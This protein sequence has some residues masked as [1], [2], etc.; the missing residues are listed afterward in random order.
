LI[1]ISSV[2]AGVIVL[3]LLALGCGGD[4]A[5]GTPSSDWATISG[6]N[7]SLRL[8]ASFKGGDPSDPSVLSVLRGMAESRSDPEERARLIKWLDNANVGSTPFLMAWAA[9]DDGGFVATVTVDIAPLQNL[10]V[11]TD[12]DRSMS[13]LAGAYMGDPR[14]WTIDRVEAQEASM[15]GRYQ[16]LG[17]LAPAEYAFIKV[18]GD[19]YYSIVYVCREDSWNKWHNVFKGSSHTFSVTP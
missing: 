4:N 9:P 8:P 16:E 18:S 12:G 3:C 19:W 5:A 10:L 13:A 11:H 2:A 7:V 14:A 6:R 15:V 1:R 17:G